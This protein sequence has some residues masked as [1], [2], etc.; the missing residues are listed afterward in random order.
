MHTHTASVEAFNKEFAKQLFKSMDA[1]ELQDPKQ[2]E[3]KI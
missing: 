3:F 1:Q 2:I